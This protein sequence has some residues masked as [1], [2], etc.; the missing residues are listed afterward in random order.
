MH[1]A[2]REELRPDGE[3]AIAHRTGQVL[4]AQRL[5]TCRIAADRR[6]AKGLLGASGLFVAA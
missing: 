4:C 6:A 2:D 3:N 5:V 1:R